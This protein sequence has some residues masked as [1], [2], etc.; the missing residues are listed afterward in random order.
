[1]ATF[2]L[3]ILLAS[4]FSASTKDTISVLGSLLHKK[5]GSCNKLEEIDEEIRSC[6]PIEFVVLVSFASLDVTQID[7][8]STS[9]LLNIF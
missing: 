2:L 5:M 8:K 7:S 6:F 1:M 4:S 9:K 3:L